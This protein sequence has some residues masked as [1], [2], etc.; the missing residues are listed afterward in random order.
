M[1]VSKLYRLI[2]VLAKIATQFDSYKTMIFVFNYN[3]FQW[4]M[5]QKFDYHEG[6]RNLFLLQINGLMHIMS[7]HETELSWKM[8]TNFTFIQ[9]S[10]WIRK[11]DVKNS[12]HLSVI[13]LNRSLVK[14]FLNN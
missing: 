11:E 2:V 10:L 4:I 3:E 7:D 1:Y 14:P 12:K 8:S 5:D 13:V 6:F 9:D